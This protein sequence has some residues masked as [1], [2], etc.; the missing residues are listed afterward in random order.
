MSADSNLGQSLTSPKEFA[1]EDEDLRDDRSRMSF[2]EHLDELRRRSSTRS[3][4]IGCRL[5]ILVLGQSHRISV[6]PTFRRTAV[7]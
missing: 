7:S 2:L 6:R 3:A 5:A 4:L 1:G